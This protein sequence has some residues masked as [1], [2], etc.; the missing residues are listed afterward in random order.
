M[1]AGSAPPRGPLKLVSMRVRWISQMRQVIAR[2][3][4]QT[5]RK[6]LVDEAAWHL[7]ALQ[8]EL[9]ALGIRSDPDTTRVVWPSLRV[10]TLGET[11]PR[12]ADFENSV[13]AVYVGS[14]WYYC[15]WLEFISPAGDPAGAAA[16]V[17]DHLGHEIRPRIDIAAW[18]RGPRRIHGTG[19]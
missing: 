8:R 5:R 11:N 4:S 17:A 9:S 7:A 14:K 1:H 2:G 16:V 13:M 3:K 10:R 15:W 6:D 19:V 18:G 12:V